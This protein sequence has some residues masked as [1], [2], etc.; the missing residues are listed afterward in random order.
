[1]F[2]CFGCDFGLVVSLFSWCLAW[3]FRFSL[4][5]VS[6][7][8]CFELRKAGE[9]WGELG[10]VGVN[11][12]QL[13]KFRETDQCAFRSPARSGLNAP[14]IPPSHLRNYKLR[15]TKQC[16]KLAQSG[17]KMVQKWSHKRVKLSQHHEKHTLWHPQGCP[18]NITGSFESGFSANGGRGWPNG[19]QIGSKITSTSS[20]KRPWN[21]QCVLDRF[22]SGIW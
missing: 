14:R 16:P 7:L 18:T 13:G 20:K 5:F 10:R 11:W 22:W 12:G 9:S 1:M 15:N 19:A 2:G 6:L 4:N 21:W 8:W 3:L 17:A